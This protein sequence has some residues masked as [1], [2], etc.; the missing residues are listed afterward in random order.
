MI[1]NTQIQNMTINFGP[2]HPAAHGVLRLL[3]TLDGEIVKYVDPHIGL[4]HRGTEKL[5][6]T[7]N[8][9]QN[10]P[11]FDRFDYVSMM[12][13]EHGF[14]Y[15]VES[16]FDIIIPK[17]AQYIRVLFSEST[18]ILNH[19]LAITTHALD[20]G[21]L[22]PFLWGF[23]EREKIMEFYEKVSGARMHAAYIRPGGVTQDLPDGLL[24]DIEAFCFR[25]ETRFS[26]IFNL[27]K[28]NRIWRSR[29]L[30]IGI[31]SKNEAINLGF[32]GVMLRGSGVF[33]DLRIHNPYEIYSELNFKIPLGIR[34]DCYDRFLIRS[35]EIF[36][37]LSIIKQCILW[38]KSI[39]NEKLPYKL[40]N[41]KFSF[42][43]KSKSKQ[44]M[45]S[46]IHHFKMSTEGLVLPRQSTYTA[47]EA[48]KGEFGVFLQGNSSSKIYRCK[49][50]APG[51]FHS[52]GLHYMSVGGFLADMVTIIG[53]QDIVFGEIDR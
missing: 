52:Q 41:F 36:E 46:L 27:L 30:N 15:A 2:Q 28:N 17:K 13:Q 33:F 6:E 9:Q 50:R 43:T 39:D 18:R 48:P 21:A 4:L 12:A 31:V 45:E 44:T 37:S 22:T 5:F 23:E 49:V 19:L 34:G 7:K 51:F 32:S 29:L 53:T 26:E 47:V 8:V 16:L 14:S 1:D 3:V 10:L 40:N 42:P 38:F 25:C 35:K 20:V 24:R 11:Y